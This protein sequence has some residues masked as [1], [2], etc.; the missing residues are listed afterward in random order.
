VENLFGK[1]LD[2]YKSEE[3]SKTIIPKEKKILKQNN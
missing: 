1:V 3:N 2:D